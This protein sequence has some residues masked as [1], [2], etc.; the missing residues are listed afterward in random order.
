M[1]TELTSV[2]AAAGI[3]PAAC[4]HCKQTIPP[5]TTVRVCNY[6]LPMF[7]HTYHLQCIQEDRCVECIRLE[8]ES[9]Q[10]FRWEYIKVTALALGSIGLTYLYRAMDQK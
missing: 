1:T 4:T 10:Y 9:D 7:R 3:T 5:G 6:A 8:A 2:R